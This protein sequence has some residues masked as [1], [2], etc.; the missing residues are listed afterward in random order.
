MKQKIIKIL[1]IIAADVRQAAV[2]AILLLFFGGSAGLLLFS[3]KALDF[4]IQLATTPTPLW[5]TVVL[6]ALCFGYIYLKNQKK[7][8]SSAPEAPDYRT[9]YFTIG[10]YKWETKIYKDG[11]FEVNEY[12]LCV[13]HNLRFIFGRYEKYCPDQNCNN[14]INNSDEFKIYE[15]AKSIIENK[16]RNN[17]EC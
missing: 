5:V 3:Q 6:V 14:K 1:K 2:P 15:S 13:K 16:I 10:N 17:E 11:D 12:P 7:I 8:Q 9:C 4:S